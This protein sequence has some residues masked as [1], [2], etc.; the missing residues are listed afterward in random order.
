MSN[1]VITKEEISKFAKFLGFGFYRIDGEGRFVECDKLANNI[2]GISLN[3]KNLSSYSI[4]DM[5]VAKNEREW[6]IKRLI[7]NECQPL[8]STL[9]LR[10]NGENLLLFDMCWCDPSYQDGGN[11]IGLIS[12]IEEGTLFPKM[13]ETFPMGLYEVDDR[14]VIVRVNKKMLDMLKYK[15]EQKLL[16]RNIK[17]FHYEENEDLKRFIKEIKEKGYANAVLK[18]KDANN[19]P[20]TIES[21][22]QKIPPYEKA[23]WGMMVD[24]TKRESYY[25]A[26]DDMP[27]GYYHIEDERVT[28][29]NKRFAEIM[30]FTRRED[31]IN[32]DTREFFADKKAGEKYFEE[33][34][35]ADKN[36]IDVQGHELAI[37][38]ANGGKTITV[39]IDSHLVR[40]HKNKVIGREGTIRDVT[41]R[42]ELENQVKEAEAILKKN[43][44]DINRFIHTFLHPVIKFSGFSELMYNMGSILHKTTKLIQSEKRVLDN[45]KEL[46]KEVFSKL[47]EVKD[48]LPEIREN[49]PFISDRD[50]VTD[51]AE[52]ELLVSVSLK[53]K[54]TEKLNDLDFSLK[55]DKK[56]FLDSKIRDIVLWFLEELDK[57]DFSK[58]TN[59]KNIIDKELIRYF[60][61]IIF[62]QL[63]RSS[64]I[65]MGEVEKMKR[66]VETLRSYIGLKK[67][68]KYLFVRTDIGKILEENVERFKP[69]LQEKEIEI[70]YR[71]SGSL[72]A[73]ISPNDFERVICNLFHNAQKYSLPGSNRFVLIKTKELQREKLVKIS[74][75][76]LGVPIKQE[77]IDSGKIWE[78]GYRGEKALESD[79]DG[80]GVGL[81]D[82]R[83]VVEAHGGEITISSKPWGD[84]A[85]NRYD[86]PYITTVTLILPKRQEGAINAK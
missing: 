30:G 83:D 4:L 11:Y 35:K 73:D 22:S 23:R 26:L 78:V 84:N 44:E 2:F 68:R 8:C 7:D 31:A 54:L 16:G 43:T 62:L 77:E 74:I 85:S 34:K 65:L 47:S 9:S 38:R 33:L 48:Y 36:R 76:S 59:L 57:I 32:I 37:K 63:I 56:A 70:R 58:L 41:E 18:L 52:R 10:V 81:A 39:S 42:I 75:E 53:E 82:A 64:R 61:D 12:K 69:I 51:D 1:M 20:L 25:R 72:R 24:V 49:I 79:R 45:S 27:T 5:Y 80:T 17:E 6:R 3:A 60:E 21:F 55:S 86:S 19:E 29:C 14:D 67:E 15:T 71:P 50:K 66:E 46:G 40:D 28:Q 13:F